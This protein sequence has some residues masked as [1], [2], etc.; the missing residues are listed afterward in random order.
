MIQK[1]MPDTLFLLILVHLHVT[2][3]KNIIEIYKKFKNKYRI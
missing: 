1:M 3:R 2:E